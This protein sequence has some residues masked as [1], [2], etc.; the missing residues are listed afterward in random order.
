MSKTE[1]GKLGLPPPASPAA[2]PA[3]TELRAAWAKHAAKQHGWP[4]GAVP[5]LRDGVF[6][7]DWHESEYAIFRAGCLYGVGRAVAAPDEAAQA[8]PA[9]VLGWLEEEISAVSIRH[10]GDPA[11][12]HDAYWMR[13]RVLALL[14]Y[15]G[16][17]FDC[18]TP[19]Q[20]AGNGQSSAALPASEQPR[21]AEA[22][23]S[24]DRV[25]VYAWAAQGFQA[26]VLVN[27]RPSAHQ[28]GGQLNGH[29]I[30][31]T[32]FYDGCAVEDWGRDGTWTLLRD[33]EPGVSVESGEPT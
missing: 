16:E 9:D 30:P 17:V 1:H 5:A 25:G 29:V 13:Q 21:A 11:Y 10:Q 32:S 6:E 2:A 27:R 31:S 20:T 8:T 18:P 33:L 3:E 14:A 19:S 24:P 7:C 15:A 26:L 28:P 22:K 12:D 23:R 4:E